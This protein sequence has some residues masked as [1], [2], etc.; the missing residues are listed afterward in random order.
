V[1][2][3]INTARS[4]LRC[5]PISK[6]HETHRLVFLKRG[7]SSGAG[8]KSSRCARTSSAGGRPSATSRISNSSKRRLSSYSGGREMSSSG[9]PSSV[10]WRRSS[11]LADLVPFKSNSPFLLYIKVL[12][13]IPSNAL[14]ICLFMKFIELLLLI[15]LCVL[16]VRSPTRKRN[17]NVRLARLCGDGRRPPALLDRSGGEKANTSKALLMWHLME[18]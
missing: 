18:S 4:Q 11:G 16:P 9:K 6:L 15:L 13:C 17:F 14:A 8:G 12:F 5:K 10:C 3:C 7:S 1:Q 2:E